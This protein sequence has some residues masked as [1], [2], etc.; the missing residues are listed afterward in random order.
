[1]NLTHNEGIKLARAGETIYGG[2]SSEKEHDSPIGA[3]H[4]TRYYRRNIDILWGG[5]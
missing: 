1:V 5:E 4:K 2:P 3:P